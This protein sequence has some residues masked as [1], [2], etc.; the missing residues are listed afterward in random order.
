[1][2]HLVI[3]R[4]LS[5]ETKQK[6]RERNKIFYSENK[7]YYLEWNRNNVASRLCSVAKQRAKKKNIP[8]SITSKDII[9]PTH[10]PILGIELKYNQ[11]T[12]AG[13]KDNSYSL[14]RI[15]PKKG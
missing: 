13:G 6:N 7:E 10:C 1:M 14:D 8:F 5:E 2:K 11:N 3:P 15:D 12:G 9:L 4:T